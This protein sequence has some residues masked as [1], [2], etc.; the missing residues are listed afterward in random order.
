MVNVKGKVENTT[1]FVALSFN[2]TDRVRLKLS[3]SINIVNYAK[4]PKD[5]D[6]HKYKMGISLVYTDEF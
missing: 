6:S 2:V 5:G 4:N 3:D 1:A